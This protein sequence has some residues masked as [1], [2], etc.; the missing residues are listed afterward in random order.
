MISYSGFSLETREN[1]QVYYQLF[2]LDFVFHGKP[3]V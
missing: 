3:F 1:S 2:E